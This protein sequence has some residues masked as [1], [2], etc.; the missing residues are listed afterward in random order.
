M[1]NTVWLRQIFVQYG[2]LRC[3]HCPVKLGIRL[4][5]L[6]ISQHKLRGYIDM[7]TFGFCGTNFNS[8]LSLKLTS[9]GQTNGKFKEVILNALIFIL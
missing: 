4:M 9:A 5:R 1:I 8:T 3:K 7:N 2:N 6:H